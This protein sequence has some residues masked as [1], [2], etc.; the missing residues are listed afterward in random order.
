MQRVGFEMKIHPEMV[1]EYQKAHDEIWP[2]MSEALER[3]GMRN[4]TIFFRGDGSLFGYVECEESHAV[5]QAGMAK[6]EVNTRWQNSMKPFFQ[7][8]DPKHAD[9]KKSGWREVFHAD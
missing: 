8:P 5:S 3:N 4:Y 7:L 2:D 1:D 6:E 9:K